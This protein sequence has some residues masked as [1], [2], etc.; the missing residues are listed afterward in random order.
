MIDLER[1]RERQRH[2][3]REKEASCQ[4]P[5]VELDPETPGSRPGLKAGA[6]PLSHPGIPFQVGFDNTTGIILRRPPLTQW[7]SHS[8]PNESQSPFQHA[9][10]GCT[11]GTRARDGR[12]GEG[13]AEAKLSPTPKGSWPP[14][15]W[16]VDPTA[17]CG[18]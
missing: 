13:R 17:G 2:R 1:D 10:S 9:H 16:K 8:A 14:G 11:V 5:N 18:I 12:R 3:R 6:K 4:E 15:L 7:A